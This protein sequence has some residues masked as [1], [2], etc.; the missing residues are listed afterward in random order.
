MGRK[1]TLKNRSQS[2]PQKSQNS[3]SIEPTT[4]SPKE[5][6]L[7]F[8]KQNV[9]E[10]FVSV[11]NMLTWVPAYL[12]RWGKYGTKW[13]LLLIRFKATR[14]YRNRLVFISWWLFRSCW[15][16]LPTFVIQVLV[17]VVLVVLELQTKVG[18]R[19]GVLD[20]KVDRLNYESPASMMLEVSLDSCI[21][22]I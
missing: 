9:F 3:F 1:R 21:Q 11:K 19:H 22:A 6:Y 16:R 17:W 8:S 10:C 18:Q 4:H 20:G 13:C 12:L 5:N 15:T 14:S 7:L 2:R